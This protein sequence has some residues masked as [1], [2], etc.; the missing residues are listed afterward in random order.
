MKKRRELEDALRRRGAV[1]VRSKRHLAFRLANGATFFT[2][3]TPGDR[4]SEKND[5]A[6]LRRLMPLPPAD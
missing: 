2:S 5:L 4:R 6:T 1:L 3:A